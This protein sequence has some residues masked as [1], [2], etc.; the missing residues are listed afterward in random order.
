[1][2]LEHDILYENLAAEPSNYHAGTVQT[3]AAQYIHLEAILTHNSSLQ[4]TGEETIA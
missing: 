1:M 2:F 3:R 4:G